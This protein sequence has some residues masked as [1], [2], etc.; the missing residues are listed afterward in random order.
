MGLLGLKCPQ[1]T[2]C[3]GGGWASLRSWWHLRRDQLR[4][5]LGRFCRSKCGWTCG[6]AQECWT[7]RSLTCKSSGQCKVSQNLLI[8]TFPV[9]LILFFSCQ[10]HC[11]SEVPFWIRNETNMGSVAHEWIPI[12][13]RFGEGSLDES[14]E[15]Y[16]RALDG[17]SVC[18]ESFAREAWDERSKIHSNR[19]ECLLRQE[20]W[21]AAASEASAALSND[22]KNVK[23][24]FRRAKAFHALGKEA[25][26]IVD[27]KVALRAEPKNQQMLEFAWTDQNCL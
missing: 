4:G 15:N 25:A 21:Q 20:Q 1:K 3:W 22:E 10:L 7:W 2:P 26:A 23:A 16:Q 8:K 13:L 24:R 6:K 19:A 18:H 14:L 9:C 5:V 17:L 27:L 11:K 12:E